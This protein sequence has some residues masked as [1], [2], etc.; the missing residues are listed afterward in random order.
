MP[1]IKEMKDA[2]FAINAK[3]VDNSVRGARQN[4][5]GNVT[6]KGGGDSPVE[7]HFKDYGELTENTEGAYALRQEYTNGR[8]KYFIKFATAGPGIGQI[9]NPWASYY[10]EGDDTKY[11]KQMGRRR[12]EFREVSEEIFSEY[13]KFLKT[14]NDRYMIALIREFRDGQA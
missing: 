2:Q 12:Y 13:L 6:E 14:R 11:E 7:F 4:F 3:A 10:R 1:T 8:K 5:I 9:L